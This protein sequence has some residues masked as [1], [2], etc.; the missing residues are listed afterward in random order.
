MNSVYNENRKFRGNNSWMIE[1]KRSKSPGIWDHQYGQISWTDQT[2]CINN[3]QNCYKMSYI[4]QKLW[5][6]SLRKDTP[7]RNK[8]S[9]I[10]CLKAN[11]LDYKTCKKTM[12]RIQPLHITCVKFMKV[13]YTSSI[14]PEKGLYENRKTKFFIPPGRWVYQ[15]KHAWKTPQTYPW[16]M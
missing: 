8:G 14:R 4:L 16:V 1:N 11:V 15:W 6:P 9:S 3:N 13:E 12:G 10:I 7:K 5:I 2:K